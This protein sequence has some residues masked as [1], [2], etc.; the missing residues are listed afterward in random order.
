[1][2]K[3]D[4]EIYE[5]YKHMKNLRLSILLGLFSAFLIGMNLLGGKITTLFGISVSVGIFLVPLTFLITDVVEEVYGKKVSRQFII[6]GVISIIA[7]L[8]FTSFFVWLEPSARYQQNDEY[9]S[10][11]GSSLRIM[12]A[13]VVA[14]AMGQLHDVWAFSFWKKKTNGKYLWLRNNLSTFFS[15]AVDTFLFMMIAFYMVSPKFDFAFV[16]SLA[17]PYYIFKLVFAA[18]DTPF[19]YAGVAWLKGGDESLLKETSN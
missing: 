14:F 10:V 7:M 17:I 15:Q 16:M 2:K 6:V 18:L 13:S 11:F 3:K 9:V 8:A 4:S 12:I 5:L 19:V 1:M